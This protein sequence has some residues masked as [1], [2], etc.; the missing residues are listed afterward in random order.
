M[1]N[2]PSYKQFKKQAQDLHSL[3]KLPFYPAKS[4]GWPVHFPVHLLYTFPI[5]E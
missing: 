5:I 4:T 1:Y 2:F 3:H